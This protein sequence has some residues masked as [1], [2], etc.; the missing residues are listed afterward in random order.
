MLGGIVGSE[1]LKQSG[2]EQNQQGKAQEAQGQLSD[3]G[4]GM[5]DRAKGTVGG[6]VASAMGD[7]KGEAIYKD[8]HDT[9]KTKQRGVEAELDQKAEAEARARQS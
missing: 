6:A 2:Q 5:M 9:G 3:L 7:T 8:L 1:S 4:G